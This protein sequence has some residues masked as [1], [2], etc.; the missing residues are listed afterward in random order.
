MNTTIMK[1][2]Y[3]WI[4]KK[5][6]SKFYLGCMRHI[7]F[8]YAKLMH[9]PSSTGVASNDALKH[10]H[11]DAACAREKVFIVKL[12]LMSWVSCIVVMCR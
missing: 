4:W 2:S 9:V 5:M 11:K 7:S 3:T 6:T 12:I 10:A 8:L 1:W